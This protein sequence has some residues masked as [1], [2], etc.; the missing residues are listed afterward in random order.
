LS[1]ILLT[2]KNLN[3]FSYPTRETIRKLVLKR[4]YGKINHQRIPLTNNRLVEGNLGKFGITSV[5]D[6]IN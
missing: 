6:L 1:L 2:G 4:G 5:D 3:N